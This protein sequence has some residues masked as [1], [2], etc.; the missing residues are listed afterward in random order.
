LIELYITLLQETS[1]KLYSYILTPL[2]R[3]TSQ[4]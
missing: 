4:S 1:L 3:T 2:R